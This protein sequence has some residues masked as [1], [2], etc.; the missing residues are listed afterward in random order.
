[1]DTDNHTSEKVGIDFL[2]FLS[3]L[4]LIFQLEVDK[5]N[6]ETDLSRRDEED[7][8]RPSCS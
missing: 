5:G 6:T 2:E 4:F 1:M 7:S 3:Y 8:C